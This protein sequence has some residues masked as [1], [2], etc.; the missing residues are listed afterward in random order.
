M[1][2]T[3]GLDNE[4][5]VKKP[6]D[7]HKFKKGTTSR[8]TII[9]PKKIVMD[10]IHYVEGVGY[11]SCKQGICCERSN[12]PKQKFAT[13]IAIYE[14]DK[15]G[16]LVDKF[17][18]ANIQVKPWTFSGDKFGTIQGIH[19]EYSLTDCDLKVKCTDEQ[20][21]KLEFLPTKES[22]YKSNDKFKKYIDSEVKKLES[23]LS[24]ILGKDLSVEV[25]QE[26]LGDGEEL[27]AENGPTD[28]DPDATVDNIASVFEDE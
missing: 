15:N 27:K 23:R 12:P 6:L 26:K 7:A 1:S 5:V 2:K 16:K 9:D 19:R 18:V 22:L 13:L 21:Q 25:L 4:D 10:D 14:T 20:Y 17:G 28:L 8:I 24:S 11:F 3:I